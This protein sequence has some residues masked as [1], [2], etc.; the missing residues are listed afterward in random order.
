MQIHLA[1]NNVSAGP[2][3]LDELNTMLASGEVVLSDLMWHS[4]MDNWQSVGEMTGGQKF[5]NPSLIDRLAGDAQN[6]AQ[7]TDQNTNTQSNDSRVADEPKRRLTV[8][9]LY[10]QAPTQTTNTADKP[11]PVS[12]ER[13][14]ERGLPKWQGRHATPTQTHLL[15]QDKVVFASI[16]SRF[17]AFAINMVLFVMA[18][19]PLQLAIVNSG[20][21]P[22]TIETASIAQYQALGEQIASSIV[23]TSIFATFFMMMGLAIIQLLLLAKRGQSLGKLVVGIRI[24]DDTSFKL[25][26]LTKVIAI[27]TLLL[28][29]IYQIASMIFGLLAPILMAGNYMLAKGNPN[30]QGWHDKL[31]KTVVVKAHPAQLQK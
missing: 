7:H 22:K 24:V 5:Y 14:S 29:V 26:N 16:G 8:A 28:F 31:S 2:Y 30:H 19:M 23:T 9:E 15:K 13:T 12:E 10:G 18:M 4:G 17:L 25:A 21:D 27:R 11:N 1:R 20:I 6:T 3:T